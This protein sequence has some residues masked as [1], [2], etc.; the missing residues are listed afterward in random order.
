MPIIASILQDLN[1]GSNPS[2][3]SAAMLTASQR[4]SGGTWTVPK[5][6]TSLIVDTAT[7]NFNVPIS[8]SGVEYS[9]TK[10]F[11]SD[12]AVNSDYIQ[13]ALP[14]SSPKVTIGFFC[15]MGPT[16]TAFANFDHAIIYGSGGDFLACS[17]RANGT[18]G[19][20][21]HTQVA[22]SGSLVTIVPNTL[23]WITMK[24]DQANLLGTI[25]VYETSTWTLV[26]ESTHPQRDSLNATLVQCGRCDAHVA[27]PAVFS[28]YYGLTIDTTGNTW[29][30][31]PNAASSYLNLTTVGAG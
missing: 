19:I 7:Q 23:Y 27:F 2:A 22:S 12:F 5:A 16:A 25:R 29:P 6:G 8:I 30:L 17:Q 13:W 14:S 15:N 31:G 4:G 21:A 3:V 28:Y 18:V 1:T 24:F 9:N 20:Q 11:R 26:G 10:G